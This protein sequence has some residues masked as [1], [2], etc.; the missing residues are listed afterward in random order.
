[1]DLEIMATK[2]DKCL[3][4]ISLILFTLTLFGCAS[5]RDM[6][7]EGRATYSNGDPVVGGDVVFT[8][9]ISRPFSMPKPKRI[10]TVKTDDDGGFSL[11]VK[12]I[13]GAV[14]IDVDL[15]P[16]KCKWR[17]DSIIISDESSVK[18]MVSLTTKPEICVGHD[19][20]TQS[21]P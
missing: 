14:D 11:E 7:V 21:R 19:R 4:R 20:T 18:K 10:G 15:L 1:M 6:E 9:L 8:Q 17:G 13:S 2:Y 5:S 3:A 16:K 12:N